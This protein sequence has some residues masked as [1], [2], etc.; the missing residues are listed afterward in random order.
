MRLYALVYGN[1][2]ED[3]AYFTD[4]EKAKRKLVIQT[5]F[6]EPEVNFQPVLYEYNENARDGH[7]IRS[8]TFWHLDHVALK[9]SG[10]DYEDM[11]SATPDCLIPFV[12]ISY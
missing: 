5:A 9:S 7:L 1:S 4:L 12:R 3:I 8:K 11:I 6:Y 2:W 10:M